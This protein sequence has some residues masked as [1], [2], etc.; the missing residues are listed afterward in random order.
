LLHIYE[1]RKTGQTETNRDRQTDRDKVVCVREGRLGTE[2]ETGIAKNER[3]S[4]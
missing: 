1:R 2:T 3:M 4:H